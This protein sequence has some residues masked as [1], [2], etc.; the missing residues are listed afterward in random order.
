MDTRDSDWNTLH[1]EKDK[2]YTAFSMSQT[3]Y[4]EDVAP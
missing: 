4:L 2:L 1:M 3:Q